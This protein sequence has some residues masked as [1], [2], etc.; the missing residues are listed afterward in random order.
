MSLVA[1][2]VI[3]VATVVANPLP[4]HLLPW[5]PS[6]PSSP[7]VAL[8]AFAATCCRCRRCGAP[9]PPPPSQHRTIKFERGRSTAE[10]NDWI[11]ADIKDLTSWLSTF[12]YKDKDSAGRCLVVTEYLLRQYDLHSCPMGASVLLTLLLPLLSLPLSSGTFVR[13]AHS[14][15]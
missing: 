7:L 4:R 1:I 8:V 14:S 10:T 6:S 9:P 15:C 2:F 11:D 13:A 3:A 12:L 5:L